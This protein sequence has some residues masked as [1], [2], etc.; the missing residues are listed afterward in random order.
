MLRFVG[1]D[2]ARA[3]RFAESVVARGWPASRFKGRPGTATPWVVD[4]AAPAADRREIAR[5]GRQ[6]RMVS[7]PLPD[8]QPLDVDRWRARIR[9]AVS[10]AGGRPR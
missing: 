5:V 4:V 6:F 9:G 3:S 2:R 7:A 1:S 10:A 8:P